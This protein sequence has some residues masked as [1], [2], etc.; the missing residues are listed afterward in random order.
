[1]AVLT[2][3]ETA[4]SVYEWDE[5]VG[6]IRQISGDRT[7]PHFRPQGYWKVYR[8]IHGPKVGES[9]HVLW[10]DKKTCVTVTSPVKGI[11]R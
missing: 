11:I 8:D 6:L 9:M 7:S 10:T 2:L 4:H 1:M 5:E 3:I